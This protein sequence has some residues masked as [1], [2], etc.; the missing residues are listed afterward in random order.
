[1]GGGNFSFRYLRLQ[2]GRLVLVFL[3]LAVDLAELQL[4]LVVLV[5]QL[6]QLNL[7]SFPDLKTRF[8]GFLKR[9]HANFYSE[10]IHFFFKFVMSHFHL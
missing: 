3:Q 9:H 8:R 7:V 10:K 4:R 2:A 6:L 1:M 5:V